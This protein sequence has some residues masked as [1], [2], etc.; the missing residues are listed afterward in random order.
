MNSFNRKYSE[1]IENVKTDFF[2]SLWIKN[3]FCFLV[4]NLSNFLRR[5]YASP[6]I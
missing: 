6:L 2:S 3:D 4:C 5:T 1:T